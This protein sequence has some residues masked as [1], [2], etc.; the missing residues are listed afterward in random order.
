MHR[1]E[2]RVKQSIRQ[3]VIILALLTLPVAAL[4]G[5]TTTF[6]G[7]IPT[8]TTVAVVPNTITLG[9]ITP[10]VTFD[11]LQVY[12]NVTT[13]DSVSWSLKAQDTTPSSTTKG[14][15]YSTSPVRNLTSPFQIWDFTLGTPAYEPLGT[16][17]Y[18]FY[19]G[20]GT[21]STNVSARFRQD[22]TRNDL[23]GAYNMIVTFT[24]VS[25]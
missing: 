12:V 19:N 8:G 3:A 20:Q 6:S 13:Y 17:I 7:S 15:M 18:T 21:G 14:F 23:S 1:G 22:V 5:T 25:A 10:P 24:W 9:T 11:P 16:G 4:A 2:W